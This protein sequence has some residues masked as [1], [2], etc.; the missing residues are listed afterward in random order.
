MVKVSSLFC[1]PLSS[2][3]SSRWKP[4]PLRSPRVLNVD[5]TKPREPQLTQ[6]SVVFATNRANYSFTSFFTGCYFTTRAIFFFSWF[7]FHTPVAFVSCPLVKVFAKPHVPLKTVPPKLY[8]D[9]SVC[10]INGM[11]WPPLIPV[12]LKKKERAHGSAVERWFH[13]H[14]HNQGYNWLVV[15]ACNCAWLIVWSALCCIVH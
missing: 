2:P 7:F 8:L 10:Q 6:G 9:L 1:S 12:G 11:Q 5:Q 15:L 3:T 13:Y 4:P 14:T